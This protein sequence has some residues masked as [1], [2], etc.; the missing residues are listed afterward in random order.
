MVAV[1]ISLYALFRFDLFPP[2]VTKRCAGA[3]T[4]FFLR[5][6]NDMG[7][8]VVCPVNPGCFSIFNSGPIAV[9]LG[10]CC[11]SARDIAL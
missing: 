4:G 2:V 9:L 7:L 6:S 10:G 11:R 1:I 8:I 3:V 5:A